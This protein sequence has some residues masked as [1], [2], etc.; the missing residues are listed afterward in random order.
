MRLQKVAFVRGQ[1]VF[2]FGLW[3]LARTSLVDPVQMP[4]C[5]PGRTESLPH[6]EEEE[7]HTEKTQFG[8]YLQVSVMRDAPLLGLPR[9]AIVL[10]LAGADAGNR[11]LQKDGPG[12]F[13]EQAPLFTRAGR[14]LFAVGDA[15]HAVPEG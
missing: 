1:S 9:G 14:V 12:L 11:V 5:P 7:H 6:Q 15:L 10:E 2:R 8:G 4:A 3:L 13:H